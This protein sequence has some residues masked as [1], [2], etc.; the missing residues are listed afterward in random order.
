MDHTPSFI[1]AAKQ[2]WALL[3]PLFDTAVEG[4]FSN[5]PRHNG[6]E[7]RM[8][9]AEPINDD[10]IMIQ[11]ELLSVVTHPKPAGSMEK[12]EHAITEWNTH[13]RLFG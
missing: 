10:K 7:A 13:I 11:K 5:C 6:L 1:D 9:L 2:V 8:L 3:N 4:T 12:I